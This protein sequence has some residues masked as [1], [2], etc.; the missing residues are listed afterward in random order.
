MLNREIQ[1]VE[2][3]RRVIQIQYLLLVDLVVAGNRGQGGKTKIPVRLQPA[4][5]VLI[6]NRCL[7][8]IRVD[9]LGIRV[10]V[11]MAGGIIHTIGCEN[12]LDI[13]QAATANR[14]LTFTEECPLI[15]FPLIVA[16]MQVTGQGK[17]I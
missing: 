9:D 7:F 10:R 16:V 13:A 2:F 11:K 8:E 6:V 17:L 4:A 1:C 15:R 3:S 14:W 5:V 12:L